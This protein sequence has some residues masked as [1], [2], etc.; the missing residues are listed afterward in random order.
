MTKDKLLIKSPWDF[1]FKPKVGMG[2][3]ELLYSDRHSYTIIKVS[4]SGKT[5]TIQRDKCTLLNRDDL[6]FHVGGFCAHC[7][8][9][10]QQRWW[11]GP[12]PDSDDIRIASL[13]KDGTWRLKGCKTAGQLIEGRHEFFDYNF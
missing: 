9:Q 3:T 1:N 10:S 8:N 7:S 12:D 13:R 4:P 6:E 5:I 2:V 11:C